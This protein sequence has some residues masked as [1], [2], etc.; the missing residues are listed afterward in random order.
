MQFWSGAF[1]G[2]VAAAIGFLVLLTQGVL[3]TLADDLPV[4]F[5]DAAPRATELV[6][7]AMWSIAAPAVLAG[8]LLA[9][10][11]L[12]RRRTAVRFVALVLVF[13]A[14]AATIGFTLMGAYA[15]LSDV[16]LQLTTG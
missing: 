5:G 14:S 2:I 15:P 12:P 4:H 8:L 13:V 6:T 10:L 9:A 16:D 1:T 7:G 11:I 3:P